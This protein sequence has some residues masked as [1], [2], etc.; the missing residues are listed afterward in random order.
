LSINVE[1]RNEGTQSSI[2]DRHRL[3]AEKLCKIL[4]E[5]S[6]NKF[7]IEK[8]EN[9]L[10][11]VNVSRLYREKHKESFFRYPVKSPDGREL[12]QMYTEGNLYKIYFDGGKQIKWP[13][14]WIDPY[15]IFIKWVKIGDDYVEIQKGEDTDLEF[16]SI[17]YYAID[18]PSYNLLVREDRM[19][20]AMFVPA[21]V[22]DFNIFLKFIDDVCNSYS[23]GK[24]EIVLHPILD[25]RSLDCS[26]KF[27]TVGMNDD[28]IIEN[29][30]RKANLLTKL[31]EKVRSWL[32]SEERRSYYESTMLFPEDPFRRRIGY[33]PDVTPV[34]G[35]H[36][37][38]FEK[39]CLC[40]WPVTDKEGEK[41]WK[42]SVWEYW[43][44]KYYDLDGNRLRLAMKSDKELKFLGKPDKIGRIDLRKVIKKEDL[45]KEHIVVAVDRKM[46][47][48]PKFPL[49]KIEFLK[50]DFPEMFK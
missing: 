28:E 45:D 18:I 36:L 9:H 21:V 32:P 3:I 39:R 23:I 38:R 24:S 12:G 5:S 34:E 20:M 31:R 29:T 25:A 4:N 19:K 47:R 48:L 7:V 42:H 10:T 27:R 44:V 50:E 37:S 17:A 6:G 43:W 33:F 26:V 22:K 15:P 46:K 41:V 14:D 16:L 8:G 49:E 11:C 1:G 40:K 13:D 35:F 30:L 2:A